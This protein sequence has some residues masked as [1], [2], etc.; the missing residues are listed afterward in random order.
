M[1]NIC[2]MNIRKYDDNDQH[3]LHEHKK[4]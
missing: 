3:M 2:Y 1:I 4:I